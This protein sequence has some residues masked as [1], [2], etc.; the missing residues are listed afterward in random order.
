MTYH[1]PVVQIMQN[2]PTKH[3]YAKITI[4]TKHEYAKIAIDIQY[5]DKILP[6]VK[7]LL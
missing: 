7:V 6:Q 4:P 3:E 5:T 2:I 1:G